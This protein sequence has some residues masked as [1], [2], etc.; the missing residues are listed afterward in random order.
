MR[1]GWRRNKLGN[2]CLLAVFG[3]AS[4][5][6]VS[7]LFTLCDVELLGAAELNP[8]AGRLGLYGFLALSLALS[9]A[10][11]CAACALASRLRALRFPLWA[12]AWVVVVY[13]AAN[14]AWDAALWQVFD[15][16]GLDAY[17]NS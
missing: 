5:K 11:P 9:L 14:A 15:Q 16:R 13:N 3:G 2:P 12:L 1:M 4:L 17:R 10:V 7:V 6:A 8:L